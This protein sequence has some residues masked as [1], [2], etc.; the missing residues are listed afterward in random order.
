MENL[1]R[2]LRNP[3]DVKPGNHMAE[4]AAVYQTADG[5]ISLSPEEVTNVIEYLLSLK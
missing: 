5:D 3:E 4:L 2:W 1:R